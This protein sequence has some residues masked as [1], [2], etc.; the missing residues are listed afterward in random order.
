M[1][2][3]II[4]YRSVTEKIIDE[5]FQETIEQILQH[6]WVLL[7]VFFIPL[8]VHFSVYLYRIKKYHAKHWHI[9]L[10]GLSNQMHKSKHSYLE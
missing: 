10:K 1:N 8:V 4:V 3:T 9:P 6:P 5:A 7:I 2:S